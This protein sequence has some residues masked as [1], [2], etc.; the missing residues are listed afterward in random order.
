MGVARNEAS[1]WGRLL[2][3]FSFAVCCFTNTWVQLAQGDRVYHF[4]LAPFPAI[5]VPVLALQAAIAGAMLVAWELC[6]RTGLVRSRWLHY[7]FLLACLPALGIAA[8]ALSQAAP[9]NLGPVVGHWWFWPVVFVLASPV[10]AFAVLRPLRAT[11]MLRGFF[12]YA[13]PAAAL[14]VI[15]GLRLGA[16]AYPASAFE[17]GRLAE[18]LPATSGPRVVWIVFDELSQNVA[19]PYRPAGLKLPNFDQMRAGGFYAA[20]AAPPSTSTELS[21]PALTLGEAVTE[22]RIAGPSRLMI[23]TASRTQLVSW[24]SVPNVFDRARRMAVNSAVVGW[25]HPYGR[26]LNRSLVDCYWANISLVP[27]TDEPAAPQ[28]LLRSMAHRVRLQATV[29]PLLGHFALFSPRP[30]DTAEHGRR[31]LELLRHARELVADPSIGLVLIHLPVPHPPG[32]YDRALGA[33]STRIGMSYLDNLALADRTIADLGQAAATAGL[34]GR[35]VLIV[36]AD[37]GW[38]PNWRTEPGWTA[39]DEAAFD[40]RDNIGVPF[41]VRFPGDSPAAYDQPF[42]TVITAPLILDILSGR[43]TTSRQ[44][45]NWIAQDGG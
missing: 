11:R 10:F 41:L 19:F 21:L 23:R 18:R 27:G 30:L 25:F 8:V 13:S 2:V 6:R 33:L 31:F 17:D 9:F 22:S 32:F 5:A 44:L 24:G 7:A 28:P 36:S 14:I 37:H 20:A 45:P 39:E 1:R 26:L 29:V 3:S 35:T 4:H 34:A 38:R 40:H 15:Q 43:L 16:L 12:L 42:N